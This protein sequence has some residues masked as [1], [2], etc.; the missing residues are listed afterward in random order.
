MKILHI[1]NDGPTKLSTQIITVQSKDNKV[2]V[3]DLL[4]KGTSYET[5]IDEIFA[6]DKVI[7]W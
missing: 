5:I 6:H 7:S 1:L 4:K 3:I 2:K